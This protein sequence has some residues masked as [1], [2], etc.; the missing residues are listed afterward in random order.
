MLVVIVE[1]YNNTLNI[2]CELFA[3]SSRSQLTEAPLISVSN[4]SSIA[5]QVCTIVFLLTSQGECEI[6]NWAILSVM[7][8][9]LSSPKLA[10]MYM[11]LR[12]Q[13]N[14]EFGHIH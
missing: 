13:F 9:N 10:T 11:S 8:Q 1:Q 12:I 7:D 5:L 2:K 3:N 6:S 14:V 4:R